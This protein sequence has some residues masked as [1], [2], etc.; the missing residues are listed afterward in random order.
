MMSEPTFVASRDG[1]CGFV[2]VVEDGQVDAYSATASK[3]SRQCYKTKPY[4]ARRPERA[5]PQLLR[6]SG[7]RCRPGTSASVSSAGRNLWLLGIWLEH[8]LKNIP[9]HDRYKEFTDELT[10]AHVSELCLER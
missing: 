3:Q 2:L 10:N 1:L 8:V 9:F 4:A 7:L 6:A 5:P